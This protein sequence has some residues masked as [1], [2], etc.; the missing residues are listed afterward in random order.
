MSSG[1]E[2]EVNLNMMLP[3]GFRFKPTDEELLLDYLKPKLMNQKLPPNMI[4]SYDLYKYN[5]IT[6]TET[7][8]KRKDDD[9]WYF[10]TTTT[11]TSQT[12][13]RTSRT[14]PEGFWLATQ[15][16]KEITLTRG[17]VDHQENPNS[18]KRK[19]T[20][21][22]NIIGYRKMLVYYFNKKNKPDGSRKTSSKK[23]AG[24][25]TDWIM[26]EYVLL[27]YDTHEG[28]DVSSKKRHELVLCQIHNSRKTPPPS[29]PMTTSSPPKFSSPIT[30]EPEVEA[31]TVHHQQNEYLPVQDQQYEYLPVQDQQDEYLPVQDQQ[32]ENL[33]VQD[34]QEEHLPVQ[35]QLNKY[36]PVQDQ[37]EEYLPVQHQQEDYVDMIL[38]NNKDLI[39]QLD[40]QEWSFSIDDFNLDDLVV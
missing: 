1:V 39:N 32:Y 9:E 17:R 29:A 4:N 27:C 15:G 19:T 10:F 37:Q 28:G 6:L 38:E 18:R 11:R 35:D 33:P 8:K 25:K 3:P 20:T 24:D 31:A 21:N 2:D 14:T 23:D 7:F 16:D 34:Q 30:Q 12:T 22:D 5:P 36:L 40:D 13:G 26:Y